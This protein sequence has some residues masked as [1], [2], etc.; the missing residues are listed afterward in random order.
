MDRKRAEK[1]ILLDAEEAFREPGHPGFHLAAPAHITMDFWGALK[2]DGVWHILCHVFPDRDAT[3]GETVFFHAVSRD[4]I[5]W[6]WLPVPIAPG[7]D[8]LRMNDGCIDFNEEGK[9]IMLYTSVPKDPSIPRTHRAAFG[10]EDLSAFFRRDEPFM[11][12]KDHGGPAFGG[13]WSDPF[14]FRAGGRTFLLMSKCVTGDGRDLLPIYEAEDDSLLRWVYRGI[15]FERS[16]EVVSFFPLRGKWVLLFS[17]YAATEYYVGDFD[18]ESLTFRPFRHGILSHGYH[19]Q[20]DPMD[21][22][23]YAACVWQA[24]DKR[25]LSGWIGGFPEARLWDGVM[26]F[27]REMDLDEDLFLTQRPIDGISSLVLSAEQGAPLGRSVRL[28]SKEG[29][30]LLSLRLTGG[31]GSLSLRVGSEEGKGLCLRLGGDSLRVNGDEYPLTRPGSDLVLLFDRTTAEIFVGDGTTAA[32]AVFPL[33]AKPDVF[34][35][36]EGG[37]LVENYVFSRLDRAK[38][39]WGRM[40]AE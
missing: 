10:T 31:K 11:T 19:R 3:K 5:R 30:F 8:E 32:T 9:P 24:G 25:I 40:E 23:L 38:P 14:V 35:E 1:A 29:R 13:G 21:R 4:L 16:G 18:P 28:S 26:A 22:G 17:P 27:P 20:D 36:T 39:G 15:L 37:L 6:E 34:W 7:E 12:L 33:P 2:K